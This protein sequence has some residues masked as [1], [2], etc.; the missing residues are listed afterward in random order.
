MSNRLPMIRQ[1]TLATSSVNSALA[2]VNR[3]SGRRKGI[4]N[5]RDYSVDSRSDSL[6]RQFVQVDP[7]F[8]NSN[9]KAHQG[10]PSQSNY[11]TGYHQ[12]QQQQQQHQ[13]VTVLVR[14][15]SE[16]RNSGQTNPLANK[17]F[18]RSTDSV[19]MGGIG[20]GQL[21]PTHEQYLQHNCLPLNYT[22]RS[23]FR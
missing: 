13:P 5:K 12:T 3:L 23:N 17:F 4:A 1:S 8:N 22:Q 9:N 10:M 18:R 6:F 15:A 20:A 7:Q 2:I 16:R 14:R 21:L 19:R 11:Y